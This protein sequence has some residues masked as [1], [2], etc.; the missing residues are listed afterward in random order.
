M[1]NGTKTMPVRFVQVVGVDRVT[2]RMA[3]ITFGGD[4]LADY[5]HKGPDQQVKLYFPKPGQTVPRLPEA[6]ADGDVMRWYQAFNAIPEP[7]RPWMRSFTL[8][9]H[10][11]VR[12]TIDIDFVLHGDSGPAAKWA[13]SAKPGDVLGMFGPSPD[14]ARPLPLA[15]SMAAADWV[16]LAG[17]EAALPAIGTLLEVVPH[18]LRV[19]V[20][21]EVADAGERQDFGSEGQV[22]VHW[23]Y[24]DGIPSARSELLL[25]AVRAAEFPPGAVFAWLGGESGKVR[26]LRRHL[27]RDRGIGK[28]A[29][30]FTGYWRGTLTQDDAPTEDDLSDARELLVHAHY[31]ATQRN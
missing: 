23:L 17:D 22:S 2:P 11:P 18:D 24:R 8:R 4:D 14:Y 27:A 28:R 6:G 29:I 30:D 31:L 21:A 10:D 3:R 13:R 26:A 9:A 16:L 12:A 19:L 7:E 1:T 20:F 15:D 25:D 5:V